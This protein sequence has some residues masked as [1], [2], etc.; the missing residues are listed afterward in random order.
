M[1]DAEPW[2]QIMQDEIPVDAEDNS[3]FARVAEPHWLIILDAHLV[4]TIGKF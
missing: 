3:R 2:M 1:D 4:D